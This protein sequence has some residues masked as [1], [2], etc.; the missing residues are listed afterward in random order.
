MISCTLGRKLRNSSSLLFRAS[1]KLLKHGLEMP[2][3]RSECVLKMYLQNL[4]PDSHVRRSSSFMVGEFA[5]SLFQARRSLQNTKRGYLT[6]R[7]LSVRQRK[8]IQQ[9]LTKTYFR[10]KG[11]AEGAILFFIEGS[12]ISQTSRYARRIDI[13]LP[14]IQTVSGQ[15][16]AC[17]RAAAHPRPSQIHH[18]RN[19]EFYVDYTFVIIRVCELQ[20]VGIRLSFSYL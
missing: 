6:T 16:T 5:T 4:F 9:Q 19:K 11:V 15:N 13:P 7:G 8:T 14:L 2:Q 3:Y 17:E 12:V 10:N 1:S 20:D 18:K